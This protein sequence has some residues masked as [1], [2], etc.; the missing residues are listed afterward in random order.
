MVFASSAF[1]FVSMSSDQFSHA[2]SEHFRIT[3]GEQ[4]ALRKFSASWNLFLLHVKHSLARTNL[5][6]TFETGQKVQI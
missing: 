3:N 2:R 4:H 6:D 5:A 1:L